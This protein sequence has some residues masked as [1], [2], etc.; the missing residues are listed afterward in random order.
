MKEQDETP[1]IEASNHS[2]DFLKKAKMMASE[3]KGKKGFPK[4]KAKM[5][6]RFGK[7]K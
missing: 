7:G 4:G 3:K 1:E 2:S 6:K 5:E